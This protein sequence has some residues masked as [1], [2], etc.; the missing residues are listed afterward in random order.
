M[1]RNQPFLPRTLHWPFLANKRSLSV[2]TTGKKRQHSSKASERNIS[3]RELAL[4]FPCPFCEEP[5]RT[6]MESLWIHCL[7]KHSEYDIEIVQTDEGKVQCT[8]FVCNQVI[9]CRF[10]TNIF[11]AC[12]CTASSLGREKSITS[13]ETTT[14]RPCY[15]RN[16][17]QQGLLNRAGFLEKEW[18]SRE[19]STQTYPS[20]QPT[21]LSHRRLFGKVPSRLALGFG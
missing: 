10:V 19:A 11:Y 14:A 4:P 9:V 6:S 1:K 17:K 2:H 16:Q 18:A 3:T 5:C 20:S 12:Y 8:F 21:V 7:R 15:H 13:K